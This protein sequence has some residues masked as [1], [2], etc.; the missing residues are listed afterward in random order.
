LPC[1]LVGVPVKDRVNKLRWFVAALPPH[2][3]YLDPDR[4]APLMIAIAS[5]MCPAGTED[6]IKEIVRQATMSDR[7]GDDLS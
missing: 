7:R 1:V 3:K 2:L 4:A 5:Q 6:E